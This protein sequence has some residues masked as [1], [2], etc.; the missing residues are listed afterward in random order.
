M[1]V[2]AFVN[3]GATPNYPGCIKLAGTA[4]TGLL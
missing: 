4:C 1:T 2:V 3:A